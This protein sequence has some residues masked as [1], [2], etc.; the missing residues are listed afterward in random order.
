MQLRPKAPGE[1]FYDYENY[2]LFNYNFIWS[3]IVSLLNNFLYIF[4]L[5]FLMKMFAVFYSKLL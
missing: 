5:L 3:K 4:F 2:S 1:D